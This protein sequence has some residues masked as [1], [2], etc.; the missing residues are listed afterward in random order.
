MRDVAAAERAAV[1]RAVA[2]DRTVDAVVAVEAEE[3]QPGEHRYL[4][5]ARGVGPP[6]LAR[7]D[8]RR[9]DHEVLAAGVRHREVGQRLAELAARRVGL[10]LPRA[11]REHLVEPARRVG[12]PQRQAIDRDRDPG[13]G[14]HRQVRQ[15]LAVEREPPV[16]VGLHVV[17]G[18]VAERQVA[19]GQLVIGWLR[20]IGGAGGEHEQGGQQAEVGHGPASWCKPRSSPALAHTSPT[21]RLLTWRLDWPVRD[22]TNQPGATNRGGH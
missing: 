15:R 8:R 3:R 1:L 16:A 4:F 21:M 11:D 18:H 17:R 6:R 20:A 19:P 14:Q 13:V 7:L 12:Q 5:A 10:D 22:R 2:I 9:C